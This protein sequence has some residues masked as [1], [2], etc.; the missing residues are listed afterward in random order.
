MLFR[1]GASENFK[2]RGVIPRAI[3][4]AFKEIA[5]RPQVAYTVRVSYVEIY[6]ETMI[7]LFSNLSDLGKNLNQ[8]TVVEEKNGNS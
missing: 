5:D 4:H 2:H 6:K 1:T 7:D 3:A 8:L